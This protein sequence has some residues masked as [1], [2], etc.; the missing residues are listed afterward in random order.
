MKSKQHKKR[1]HTLPK[2]CFLKPFAIS[3]SSSSDLCTWV[4]NFGKH[5]RQTNL[6]EIS[7]VNDFYTF[8][9]SDGK[10][11][12]Q[13]EDFLEFAEEKLSCTIHKLI[14]QKN[15]LGFTILERM[16]IASFVAMMIVRTPQYRKQFENVMNVFDLA[17]QK[18]KKGFDPVETI[19]KVSNVPIG[20][21]G[22]KPENIKYYE[23]FF[24]NNLMRK[25]AHV[26]TL[27]KQC[28]SNAQILFERMHWNFI[29]AKDG[30]E[31]VTCD[32]PVGRFD[33][34]NRKTMVGLSQKTVCIYFPISPDLCF[35]ANYD[36]SIPVRRNLPS[37]CI[38][39][40]EDEVELI[41][42]RMMQCA[43]RD[44]YSYSEDPGISSKMMNS[45]DK[46]II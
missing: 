11:D 3:R 22:F 13:L 36:D 45:D 38:K 7:V 15:D 28:E 20:K 41:N 23:S 12:D 24:K 34:Y 42:N 43:H 9:G 4:H 2:H 5:P 32:D 18:Y 26:L 33:E 37:I 29:I 39:A 25:N 14:D 31:F 10:K 44:V 16:D 40:N 19:R 35:Y 6:N 30:L 27:W 46:P 8:F 17:C 21:I 1:Q